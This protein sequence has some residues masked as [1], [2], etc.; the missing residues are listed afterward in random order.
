[1]HSSDKAGFLL[2]LLDQQ[3]ECAALLLETLGHEATALAR[4]NLA[5]IEIVVA[6]K[7]RHLERLNV[8]SRQRDT[9]LNPD[10]TPAGR[11]DMESFL[12]RH[13]DSRL[14]DVWRNLRGIVVQ[15]QLQNQ[16]NGG[17]IE[18]SRQRVRRT[19]SLLTGQ[20]TEDATYR[21]NGAV[22]AAHLANLSASA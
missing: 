14:E 17:L 5:A 12:Q 15:C 20:D 18:Q 22:E 7:H 16:I 8:L 13:P 4:N 2:Q 9:M 1:M 10:K 3:L 19:L 6:E 21:Q 11:Q